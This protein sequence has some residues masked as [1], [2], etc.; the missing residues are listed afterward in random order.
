[1]IHANAESDPKELTLDVSG[2][3]NVFD[4][5][6]NSRSHAKVGGSW[7]L[8]RHGFDYGQRSAGK[9]A[10]D[11]TGSNNC[12]SP[13][14]T[15]TYENAARQS[16]RHGI[17][18]SASPL[19][20]PLR[21]GRRQHPRALRARVHAAAAV[22]AMNDPTP[23]GP[24]STSVCGSRRI[25]IGPADRRRHRTR[26]LGQRGLGDHGPEPPGPDPG[27]GP[28]LRHGP[29]QALA[30]SN[31]TATITMVSGQQLNVNGSFQGQG[32]NVFN[33]YTDATRCDHR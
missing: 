27:D 9:V 32:T 15:Q 16:L 29:H 5:L 8:F 19:F 25:P 23:D 10:F 24:Q 12:F 14:P 4:G 31:L 33:P 1:M 3:H 20:E 26:L 18:C 2:S 11:L 30:R 13:I 21:S 28:L 7:N 6:L 22:A 17:S